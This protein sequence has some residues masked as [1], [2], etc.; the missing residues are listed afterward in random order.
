MWKNHT[1]LYFYKPIFENPLL[2]LLLKTKITPNQ[3]TYASILCILIASFFILFSASKL[4]IWAGLL[5]FIRNILDCVDGE[6]ARL[7]KKTS[8][9]GHT[10]DIIGDKLTEYFLPITIVI[11]YLIYHGFNIRLLLT[12]ILLMIGFSLRKLSKLFISSLRASTKN[13]LKNFTKY[14]SRSALLRTTFLVIGLIT[15]YHLEGLFVFSILNILGPF[16]EAIETEVS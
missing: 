6:L 1:H 14:F 12:M 9:F 10:L 5:L 16:K 11:N 13:T 7:L 2:K 15:G 4:L 3:V 8:D